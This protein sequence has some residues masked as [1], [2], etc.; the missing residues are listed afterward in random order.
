MATFLRHGDGG[1]HVRPDRVYRTGVLTPITGYQPEADVQA[2][3]M[4]FTQG[5]ARGLMLEGLGAPGPLKRLGLRIKAAVNQRKARRFMGVQGLGALP[6]PAYTQVS[7]L[8]PSL[9]TH[10]T[11]LM[12]LAAERAGSGYPYD[13]AAA[14]G[15]RP[16]RQ[17]YR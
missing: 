5:P 17:W 7:T 14:L 16:F 6:G 11:T 4:D 2:V 8:T 3:A 10:T 15:L 9:A 13:A 12:D 1:H